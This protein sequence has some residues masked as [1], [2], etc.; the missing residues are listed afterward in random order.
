MSGE[1]VTSTFKKCRSAVDV[2]DKVLR[3][4]AREINLAELLLV[5]YLKEAS[6]GPGCALTPSEATAVNHLSMLV[7]RELQ[8]LRKVKASEVVSV[9]DGIVTFCS[10][11]GEFLVTLVPEEELQKNFHPLFCF[12]NIKPR[13][14]KPVTSSENFAVPSYSAESVY[15]DAC[16]EFPDE[17]AGLPTRCSTIGRSIYG[18]LKYIF[19][20]TVGRLDGR[21]PT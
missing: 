2:T 10:D 6:E 3:K 4:I 18:L 11:D 9:S 20:S 5:R 14:A 19:A 15:Y 16:Y 7:L 1:E 21:Q 12:Q 8:Y 17:T 13:F